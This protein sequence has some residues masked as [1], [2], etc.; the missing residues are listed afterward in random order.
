MTTDVKECVKHLT[1]IL[2]AQN[3]MEE[4]SAIKEQCS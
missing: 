3:E 4:V 2:Q 1:D